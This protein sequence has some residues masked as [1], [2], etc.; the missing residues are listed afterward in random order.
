M[1]TN[2]L[3]M[4]F[5]VIF[6]IALLQIFN[7]NIYAKEIEYQIE[8]YTEE[9]KKWVELPDEEKAKYTMPRMFEVPKTEN[10]IEKNFYLLKSNTASKFSLKDIIP[11]NVTI[12][13]QLSTNTCWAF[14]G[15]AGL[16]SNL[17]IQDYLNGRAVK[18]YDFS[19]R[20]LEYAVTRGFKNGK[21]NEMGYNRSLNTGGNSYMLMNYLT[22]GM[23]AIDESQMP[24]ENNSNTIDINEIQNKVVKTKVNDIIQFPSYS[25]TEDTT[26]IKQQ[27]KDH[28]QTKGGVM[29]GIYGAHIYS[30]YYNNSTGAIYCDN[31]SKCPI[32]HEVLIIGWDDNYSVNNFVSKHRPKNPGAWIVKNSWGNSIGDKGYMYVSYEDVNIYY[33][34]FG[35]EKASTNIDYDNIYQYNEL[36]YNVSASISNASKVYLAN[37]FTKKTNNTEYITEVA[38]NVPES[39]ICKVYV[40]ANGTGKNM[41][42]L[43]EVQLKE[44]MLEHLTTGYH[45]LEFATP[46]KIT[47]NSFVV[48]VEIQGTTSNRVK[49]CLE[50]GSNSNYLYAYAQTQE[51]KCF[52]TSK[53][54]NDTT[55]SDLGKIYNADST[56]KAFTVNEIVSNVSTDDLNVSYRTHVENVGWQ[57]YVKNGKSSGTSGQSLRLEAINIKLENNNYGGEIKYSTHVQNIGW[58]SFKEDGK[59]AGTSGQS[60]RLEAIQIKLTG[61]ISE[62]YD[63]YYRVH[64][65]NFGWLDWAKNGETSGSTGYGYRLEAIQIRLIKKGDSAP[66]STIAPCKQA[67]LSYQTHVEN[68][69]WQEMMNDGEI[70]GTSG[71]SLRLEGIKI[72]LQDQIYSGNIEYCTHVENIGWQ[73]Y[74]K[75]GEMSGT[76]GRSLRLEA[77][78]IRLTGKMA[79]K[80][81]IY[82]RVHSQNIGWMGW[83]K[84]GQSSGTSGYGYRLEAIQICLVDKGG[85]APGSTSNCYMSN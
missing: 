26:A 60:L 4:L 40:N 68:I 84:N 85:V 69:G 8:E 13:N 2:K 29:A 80:Y 15:L 52:V 50:A 56:I 34:L 32:N 14:A 16:E 7:G 6:L 70:S 38:L 76:S 3:V 17:A 58:Q 1:K 54:S 36:G 55:W 61:E 44:G 33:D 30:D 78:K 41:N 10:N 66:G 48:V 19:E 71:Q 47:S 73:E 75:N 59:M 12:K 9:Y 65:E 37:E 11:S 82:Y 72:S 25:S 20:H 5:S 31:K 64:C 35:I 79:E 63:V 51:K 28:I 43:K 81:D 77:I 18:V 21:I 53:L 74:R 57:E 67:Y 49:Y 45:T 27:I 62:Y 46:I 42:D 23:G 83:A 39:C 24:F 22:N